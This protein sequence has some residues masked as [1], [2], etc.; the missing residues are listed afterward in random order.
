MPLSLERPKFRRTRRTNFLD[1]PL[2]LALALKQESYRPD[3]IR[4][5]LIPK[6]N[7]IGTACALKQCRLAFAV[8]E[9]IGGDL[10]SRL[11][12]HA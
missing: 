10:P 4:K 1:V 12:A 6:A 11:A 8:I 7:S 3:P 9:R 2:N 5:V